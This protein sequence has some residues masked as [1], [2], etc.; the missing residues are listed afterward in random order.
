MSAPNRGRSSLGCCGIGACSYELHVYPI[1][2]IFREAYSSLISQFLGQAPGNANPPTSADSTMTD[3]SSSS[4]SSVTTPLT[5]PAIT[6]QQCQARVVLGRGMTRRRPLDQSQYPDAQFWTAADW[7]AFTRP[8]SGCKGGNNAVLYTELS[9]QEAGDLRD[10]I[11]ELL[12]SLASTGQ[13]PAQAGDLGYEAKVYIHCNLANEYPTLLQCEGGR[14][15]I[16]RLVTQYYSNWWR[17]HG[18]K[19]VVRA[20]DLDL[21][22]LTS[23]PATKREASVIPMPETP[24]IKK[25]RLTPSTS[26]LATQKN[27]HSSTSK[28]GKSSSVLPCHLSHHTLS[29]ICYMPV[30]TGPSIPTALNKPASMLSTPT[31]SA[32]STSLSSGTV[33]RMFSQATPLSVALV[34]SDPVLSIPVVQTL[35]A[36]ASS[37]LASQPPVV[38]AC[39]SSTVSAPFEPTPSTPS[40][41]SSVP[42]EPLH[43]APV[44]SI[45]V[46]LL[47]TPSPPVLSLPT[48]GHATRYHTEPFTAER[49]ASDTRVTSSPPGSPIHVDEG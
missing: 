41:A 44:D 31:G 37:G 24:L 46:P 39:P 48:P 14:R 10:C 28:Q 18:R 5:L 33:P 9:E 13:A 19:R 15:K 16:E 25:A 21:D 35:T 22:S 45:S 20:P 42:I 7:R 29:N 1:D 23:C 2:K 11:Y 43:H 34:P 4:A 36:L 17:D 32:E 26:V 49:D 12:N 6:F 40:R 30:F 3:Q 47:R 27:S 8:G 38:L